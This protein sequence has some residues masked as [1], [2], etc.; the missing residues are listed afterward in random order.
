MKVLINVKNVLRKIVTVVRYR[1][2]TGMFALDVNNQGI[3]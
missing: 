3:T 2:R 1:D